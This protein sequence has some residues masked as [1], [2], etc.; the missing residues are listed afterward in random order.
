MSVAGEATVASNNVVVVGAGPVGILM[1]LGL[2]RHGVPVTVLERGAGVV[3][4]PRAMVYHW[5]VLEGLE[6]LG[7]LDEAL[8]RGFTKQDYRYRVLETGELISWTMEAL[9]D[10]ERYPFNLHLGQ[11]ELAKIA[12]EHLAGYP[13]AKVIWGT[14]VIG[15]DQDDRGVDVHAEG[16]DGTID[17]RAAWVVGADGAGSAV[18]GALG[19]EF[20]GMTWPERFVATNVRYDFESA[21]YGQANMVIDPEYG[22]IVAKIDTTGLWRVTY[23]ESLDLPEETVA[24]RIPAY[25]AHLLGP[26]AHVEVD[27]FS[28]YR[29]HQRSAETYRRGRVI[30]AGDAAHATNPTGGLGLTSGLFDTFVLY[31]ALAAVIRGD[32]PDSVL[33]DYAAERRR[34]FLEV[35]S[36]AASENKRLIYSS[37]DPARLAED[38]AGLRA[39]VQSPERLRERLVFPYRLRTAPLVEVGD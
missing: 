24:D 35:A 39:M 33:N 12:L 10:S 32:A 23:M 20:E 18:R 15:L 37:T 7:V 25:F 19:I 26:D 9:A 34:V 27:A 4:A 17:Y 3:E 21:G 31:P 22:C 38:L 5:S 29:M 11:N 16:P 8:S 1:A 2:A 13:D 36:P 6:Q 14:R 30:L 28:P